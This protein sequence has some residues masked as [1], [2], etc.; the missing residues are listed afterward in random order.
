VDAIFFPPQGT[1]LK[2]DGQ[3]TGTLLLTA[4]FGKEK[5]SFC[6]FL[7]D[8]TWKTVT[9]DTIKRLIEEQKPA[10]TCFGLKVLEPWFYLDMHTYLGIN[11]TLTKPVFVLGER[12]VIGRDMSLDD[13][14]QSGQVGRHARVG[15]DT[16][17]T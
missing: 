5:F 11:T 1:P 4:L 3:E 10:H 17:L 8:S 7:R 2:I 6:V 16:K 15:M 12:S 13:K 14:E 9:I